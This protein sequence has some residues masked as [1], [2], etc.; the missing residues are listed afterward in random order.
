MNAFFLLFNINIIQYYSDYTLKQRMNLKEDIFSSS[1]RSKFDKISPCIEL[2]LSTM[3]N[4]HDPGKCVQCCTGVD[5]VQCVQGVQ[6][7]VSQDDDTKL[8]IL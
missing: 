3:N 6:S 2:S 7:D 8:V 5:A 4:C 1:S